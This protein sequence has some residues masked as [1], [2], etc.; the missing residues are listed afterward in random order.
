VKHHPDDF[1]EAVRALIARGERAT[2]TAVAAEVGVGYMATAQ[3]LRELVHRRRL[4]RHRGRTVF[5]T[6]AHEE[7]GGPGCWPR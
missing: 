6:P 5:Y 7:P 3:A 1:A 2:I 4:V